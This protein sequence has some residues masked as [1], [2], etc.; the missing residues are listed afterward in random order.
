MKSW[1]G[2]MVSICLII[3]YRYAA[4]IG[5]LLGKVMWLGKSK[6]HSWIRTLEWMQFNNSMIKIDNKKQQNQNSSFFF[7]TKQWNSYC[8]EGKRKHKSCTEIWTPKPNMR[9]SKTWHLLRKIGCW[10]CY[11][12]ALSVSA[13]KLFHT[14][15]PHPYVRNSHTNTSVFD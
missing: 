12:K 15:L 3:M 2:S 10:V 6:V 14:C 9:G 11:N 5:L 4:W 1:L 7:L 13:C 8:G